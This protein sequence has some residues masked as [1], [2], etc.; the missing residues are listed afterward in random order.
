[1]WHDQ[2]RQ[3]SYLGLSCSSADAS[4]HYKIVD[5]CCPSY[6]EVDKS[7]DH[8]LSINVLKNYRIS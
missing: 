3:L 2:H 4:F 6:Y 1:M 5:L 8:L 7:D